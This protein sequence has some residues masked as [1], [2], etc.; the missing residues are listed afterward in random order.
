MP[1][2]TYGEIHFS[3]TDGEMGPYPLSYGGTTDGEMGPY[4]LSYGGTADG[5]MG[6]Y[7]LEN[8]NYGESP[9]TDQSNLLRP[10][11]QKDSSQS[12]K[13]RA[14][15]GTTAHT[16]PTLSC[17]PVLVRRYTA[18]QDS[19]RRHSAHGRIVSVQAGI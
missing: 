15:Y 12:S 1:A 5:E 8:F 14:N 4:P 7:P 2:D 9:L 19:F 6:P 3:T 16:N 18:K 10:N 11:N 13:N 17:T